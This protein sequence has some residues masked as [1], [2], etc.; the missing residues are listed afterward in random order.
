M[1]L[2]RKLSGFLGFSR[3]EGHEVRGVE[4]D[5]NGNIAPSSVNVAAAAA[6]AQ[7]Q[8]VPLRGFS[9][10]IQVPVERAQLGP[11]LVHC[12]SRDGG[13][14]GLRWYA[15]RLRIDEDGDVADEFL[16]EVL[17]DT[18]SSTEEH[19]RQYPRFELKYTTK[20]AKITSQALSA[21][22]K[23]QHRVEHQ[24]KLEWI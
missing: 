3:E 13:V 24:G 15:K 20:P 2:F 9:V 21:A 11:I 18:R 1:G 14:Q 8:N 5:T 19:H 22:G 17:E 23:I 4:D 7:A 12:S 6:A 10:P 16:E